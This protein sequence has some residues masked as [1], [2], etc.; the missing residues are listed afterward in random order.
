MIYCNIISYHEY[1]TVN[2][3]CKHHYFAS[4]L[5]MQLVKSTKPSRALTTDLQ[6]SVYAEEQ[7]S[8]V[9]SGN[10]SMVFADNVSVWQ[11]ENFSVLAFNVNEK[12][13]S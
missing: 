11:W 9:E 13:S 10:V 1:P 12:K 6:T 5:L 7:T 3:Q 4:L 8:D 2:Y